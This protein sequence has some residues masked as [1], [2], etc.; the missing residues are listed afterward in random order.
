MIY[1]LDW[2]EDARLDEWCGVL[3]RPKPAGVA[4]GISRPR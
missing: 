4:V 1:D 2:D 3:G